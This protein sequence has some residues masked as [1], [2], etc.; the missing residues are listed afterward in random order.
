MN[1][2]MRHVCIQIKIIE[3]P[4]LGSEPS[5]GSK[6]SIN[7]C[8]STPIKSAK[9]LKKSR[10]WNRSVI[11]NVYSKTFTSQRITHDELFYLLS[12]QK[13]SRKIWL[14]GPK[15]GPDKWSNPLLSLNLFR[16]NKENGAPG[17]QPNLYKVVYYQWLI[18]VTFW[19]SGPESGP[20]AYEEAFWSR[21]RSFDTKEFLFDVFWVPFLQKYAIIVIF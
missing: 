2:G 1:K 4:S 5:D 12:L 9:A 17:M 19:K 11:L 14:R 3:A 7:T 16:K 6:K 8:M 20:R 18:E 10:L 15:R 21:P 13:L